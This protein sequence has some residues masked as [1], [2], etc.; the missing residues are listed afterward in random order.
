[1]DLGAIAE[2]FDWTNF[3]AFSFDLL[4]AGEFRAG[5][6]PWALP[7]WHWDTAA[8]SGRIDLTD[9]F[10]SNFNKP[11]RRRMLFT[12]P[13]VVL[14]SSGTFRDPATGQVYLLGQSRQ[15]SLGGT[16]Y[17]MLTVCHLVSGL[18]AG[19]GKVTSKVVQGAGDDLGWLVDTEVDTYYGDLELRSSGEE[20]S[21]KGIHVGSH[22]LT[23]PGFANLEKYDFFHLNGKSYKVD[24][25]YFDS[26]FMTARVTEVGDDRLDFTIEWDSG[27]SYDYD[28]GTATH[29]VV[30]RN[31]SGIVSSRFDRREDYDKDS[32][33]YL[34]VFIFQEHVGFDPKPGMRLTLEGRTFDIVWVQEDRRER[35]WKLRCS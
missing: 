28:L 23:L 30:S 18:S 7:A 20:S 11:L 25:P 24:E 4:P 13:D 3:D 27:G 8:F 9:R 14:P 1:M 31:V 12:R 29:S 21:T 35:Q 32:T 33:D 2:Y 26:G 17:N 16:A 34:E 5:V 22:F 19:L 10:L 6:D 15:D